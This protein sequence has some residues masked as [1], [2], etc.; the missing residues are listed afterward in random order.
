MGARVPAKP[1]CIAII[2]IDIYIA[3][4]R[5]DRLPEAM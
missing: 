2:S 1:L 3:L 5:R 4:A